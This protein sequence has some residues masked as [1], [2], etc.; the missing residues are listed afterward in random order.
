M[1]LP[2]L[3]R[4]VSQRAHGN[5]CCCTKLPQTPTS[6]SRVLTNELN[7]TRGRHVRGA[8]ADEQLSGSG[9][10]TER[11]RGEQVTSA[12]GAAAKNLVKS[13]RVPSV[14]DERQSPRYERER[15]RKGGRESVCVNVCVCV[16]GAS[17]AFYNVGCGRCS[18]FAGSHAMSARSARVEA[19]SDKRSPFPLHT[20]HCILR[21]T[22]R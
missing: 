20:R 7:N 2:L 18:I 21:S 1:Q 19:E 6:W 8:T 9:V 12:A 11:R 3:R 17:G 13:S 14:P 5:L 22:D 15:E 10:V 4:N 16:C